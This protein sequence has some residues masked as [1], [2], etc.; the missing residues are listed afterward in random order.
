MSIDK[1]EE[2][3]EWAWPSDLRETNWEETI[4]DVLV[5]LLRATKKD[6]NKQLKEGKLQADLLRRYISQPNKLLRWCNLDI[7]SQYKQLWFQMDIDYLSDEYIGNLLFDAK[8]Q[9]Q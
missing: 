2:T 1:L 4:S 5:R 3:W 8:K 6:T 7:V 9:A